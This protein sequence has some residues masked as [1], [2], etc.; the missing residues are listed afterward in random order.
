M[1][2]T[3]AKTWQLGYN[4]Q[5]MRI[6]KQLITD[7]SGSEYFKLCATHY[8][9]VKLLTGCA[10]KNLSI[11]NS[12]G[13]CA[14]RKARNIASGILVPV[15]PKEGVAAKAMQGACLPEKHEEPKLKRAKLVRVPEIGIVTC[16]IEGY[17]EVVMKRAR[18]L[19]EPI[20]VPMNKDNILALFEAIRHVGLDIKKKDLGTTRAYVKSGLYVK[21]QPVEEGASEHDCEAEPD[22]LAG[23]ADRDDEA[24]QAEQDGEA[25]ENEKMSEQPLA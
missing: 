15:V 21:S 22:E 16:T 24:E 9:T 3:L 1:A 13:I 5:S 10:E 2:L 14:L 6:P 4:G 8:S 11:A 7:D 18:E 12:P 17:G 25:E 20:L 19:D 23:E